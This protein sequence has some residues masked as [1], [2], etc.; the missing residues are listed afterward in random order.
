[1]ATTHEII[2][3]IIGSFEKEFRSK[4]EVGDA[5]IRQINSLPVGIYGCIDYL[6][7]SSSVLRVGTG[8]TEVS[9]VYGI[10][11]GLRTTADGNAMLDLYDTLDAIVAWLKWQRFGAENVSP[12]GAREVS[13][14]RIPEMESPNVYGI[15][16]RLESIKDSSNPVLRQILNI[17]D[18]DA[19]PV[20]VIYLKINEGSS[21][22]IW[23]RGNP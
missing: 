3:G 1:M 10:T 12:T 2:D 5:V 23:R 19:K 13:V 17:D 21:M 18:P 15:Q 11:I 4:L 22:E 8:E 9:Q 7:E 14:G 16:F 20:E 6:G